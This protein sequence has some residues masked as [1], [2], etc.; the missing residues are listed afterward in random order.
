MRPALTKTLISCLWY[1]WGR[2]STY[3]QVFQFRSWRPAKPKTGLVFFRHGFRNLNL[4]T[5]FI[6]RVWASVHF[7]IQRCTIDE[8]FRIWSLFYL[9]HLHRGNSDDYF[10]EDSLGS[11]TGLVLHARIQFPTDPMM[12]HFCLVWFPWWLQHG[13]MDPLEG[14][15]GW[16]DCWQTWLQNLQFF[17]LVIRLSKVKQS[18]FFKFHMSMS[19]VELPAAVSGFSFFF[20]SSK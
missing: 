11:K 9:S 12:D 16:G 3:L 20:N 15:L 19:C 18:A 2:S 6:L 17:N 10:E 4:V 7:R 1:R 5:Y 13:A 14:T 8:L